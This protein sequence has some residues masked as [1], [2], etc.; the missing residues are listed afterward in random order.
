MAEFILAQDSINHNLI[1]SVYV[2][3]EKFKLEELTI[4]QVQVWHVEE[5]AILV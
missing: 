3:A 5:G 1:N 2:A 4:K